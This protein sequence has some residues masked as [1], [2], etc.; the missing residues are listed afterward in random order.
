MLGRLRDRSGRGERF[1]QGWTW[2]AGY[3]KMRVTS[4]KVWVLT[5][6]RLS[7]QEFKKSKADYDRA[8]MQTSGID[9]FCSSSAW[10]ISAKTAFSKSRETL[11]YR[12]DA[13]YVVLSRKI[14]RNNKISL[15]PLE[16]SWCLAC[17]LV[18]PDLSLLYSQF[19]ACLRSGQLAWDRLFLAG[20]VERSW[21][22]QNAVAAFEP[23]FRLFQGPVTVRLLA[24]LSEG[25][26]G[27]LARRSAKF[28]ENIRRIC[29]K[30]DQGGFGYEFVA[31]RLPAAREKVLFRRMMTIEARSW[32]G[33][34]GEGVNR[35]AMR[36]FYRQILAHLSPAGGV[37]LLFLQV[38]GRDI[39]YI[40]GGV[41]NGVYRGFQFSFDEDFAHF[42]AGNLMQI[43]MIRRLCAEGVRWYDLGTDIPY[44]RNWG[45]QRLETTG[46]FVTNKQPEC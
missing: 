42:S 12:S 5:L 44:K 34:A 9:I 40:F 8:V 20:M 10:V 24:D 14:S 32:K 28:R 35:G 2:A 11:I 13:G 38:D 1:K 27:F 17:P 45:E 36:H 7:F 22:W 30:A 19:G 26:D 6:H 25:E 21:A 18:G 46:I 39:G 43:E 4:I 31:D 23:H 33:L 37:R 15:L 16:A 41:L 29:R 3:G